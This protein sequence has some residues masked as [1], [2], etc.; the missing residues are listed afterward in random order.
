M[1]GTTEG[2]SFA[3]DQADARW[4]TFV[5]QQG[6]RLQLPKTEFNALEQPKE[7]VVKINKKQGRRGPLNPEAKQ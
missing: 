3:L 4:A 6:F 5:S 1:A 2:E 7:L